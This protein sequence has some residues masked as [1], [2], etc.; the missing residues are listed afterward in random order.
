MEEYKESYLLLF[1]AV[2]K[3]LEAIDAQNFGTAKTLLMQAQQDAEET[4]LQQAE[5]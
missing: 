2:S 5:K 1:R 4:F 3:A